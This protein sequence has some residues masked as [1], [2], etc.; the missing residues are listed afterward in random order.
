MII[1]VCITIRLPIKMENDQCFK[2]CSI[3]KSV[4]RRNHLN[5]VTISLM[6]A[7]DFDRQ[8]TSSLLKEPS[9]FLPLSLL[10]SCLH[11]M[12]MPT[13]TVCHSQLIYCFIQTQHQHQ[14]ISFFSII[15]LHSTHC[16]HHAS[17]CP[18]QNSY[19]A[20]FHTPCFTPIQNCWPH[21]AFVNSPFQL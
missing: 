1:I 7:I 20:S 6:Q 15:E 4:G 2:S 8:C 3:P 14:I 19:L 10:L 5:L 21:L 16:C 12:A 18:L 13:Q 17:L 9:C 11:H